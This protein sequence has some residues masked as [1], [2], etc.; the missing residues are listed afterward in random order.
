MNADLEKKLERLKDY[1]R[2]LGSVAIAYSSGVDSTFL[3]K[4]ASH[5]LG[6]KAIAITVNSSFFPERERSEASI[7]CQKNGIK[8]ITATVNVLDIEK[9]A[10][11][12]PDR[13]YLCKRALF[14]RM[15][16]IAT[17]QGIENLAEGSNLDDEGDYRPGLKAI[18]ELNIKSPLRECSFTKEDIRLLSKEMGLDTWDKPSYACLASRVPYGD[19]IT[20]EKLSMIER[21]EDFLTELG[22]GQSRVRH[23]GDVAR[24]E[25]L[26]WEF[27]KL[28]EAEVR[29][30][31]Y[32]KLNSIGF[33]YVTLDI[34]GFRTG[35]M[36][37]VL[38]WTK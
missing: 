23:H 19:K 22:F 5:E 31:V 25:L 11:N 29:E 37:E 14:T 4:V 13:C 32:S 30:K 9:V 10:D 1:L 35:S 26:P 2:K 27:D 36:N 7:F 24:I 38:Q 12:P 34:R 3:L 16:E 28:M 18:A 15:K 33:K 6:D 17:K 21:S 8:H 20:P